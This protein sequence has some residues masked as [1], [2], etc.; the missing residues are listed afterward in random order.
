MVSARGNADLPQPE[1]PSSIVTWPSGMVRSRAARPCCGAIGVFPA[2]PDPDHFPDRLA[3]PAIYLVDI[4]L[5]EAASS[6]SQSLK[7]SNLGEPAL[8]G[9]YTT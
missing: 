3:S 8:S 2:G 6:S 5:C 7:A 4:W 1:G 9:R